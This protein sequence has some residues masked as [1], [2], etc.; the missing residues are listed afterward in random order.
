MKSGII[1]LNNPVRDVIYA[2]NVVSDDIIKCEVVFGDENHY[3]DDKDYILVKIGMSSSIKDAC[4]KTA[5]ELSI[6]ISKKSAKN[7][8][9]VYKEICTAYEDITGKSLE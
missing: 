9:D 1:F 3:G 5:K 2:A 7:V 4:I 8:D 6:A